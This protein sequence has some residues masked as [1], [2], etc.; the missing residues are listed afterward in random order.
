MKCVCV[1]VCVCVCFR[2]P[3]SVQWISAGGPG[4]VHHTD[5]G[6][7]G[8]S[9][10]SSLRCPVASETPV[11]VPGSRVLPVPA[12]VLRAASLACILSTLPP[13]SGPSL[14]AGRHRPGDICNLY[15]AIC[16]D[17]AGVPGSFFLLKQIVS[18][19]LSFPAHHSLTLFFSSF[20]AAA[21]F[22]TLSLWSRAHSRVLGAERVGSVQCGGFG[23]VSR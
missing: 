19:I 11:P 4:L 8:A 3:L 12:S 5:S 21:L 23:A 16:Y 6:G 15:S 18:Q 9:R 2:H 14:P 10:S 20:F 17:W 22:S 13:L 7:T 1:C